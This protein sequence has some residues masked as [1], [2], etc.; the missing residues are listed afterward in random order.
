MCQNN[1]SFPST[2]Q[3]QVKAMIMSVRATDPAASEKNMGQEA[4]ASVAKNK[5]ALFLGSHR[6][7]TRRIFWPLQGAVCQ[8]PLISA[9]VTI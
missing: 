7:D 6:P 8:L 3:G 2:R 9:C 5:R 4:K 1:P